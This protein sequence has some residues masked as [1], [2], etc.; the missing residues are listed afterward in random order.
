[1]S[2]SRLVEQAR[3]RRLSYVVGRA[4]RYTA[5]LLALDIPADVLAL[6]AAGATLAERYE[7]R[8]RFLP[9]VA[10][11]A[12]CRLADFARIRDR[13]P[14]WRGPLGFVRYL[15]DCWRLPSA[16]LLPAS[17]VNRTARHVTLAVQRSFSRPSLK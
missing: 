17:A 2:W 11:I 13:E 15:R 10:G 16:W 7:Y 3:R 6:D 5:S 9:G 12:A 8:A 14:D 1:M 4:L